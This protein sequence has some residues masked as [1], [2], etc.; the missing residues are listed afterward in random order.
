[1][2]QAMGV[3]QGLSRCSVINRPAAAAEQVQLWNGVRLDL[4]RCFSSRSPAK[5]WLRQEIPGI[6]AAWRSRLGQQCQQ[7]GRQQCRAMLRQ[8]ACLPWDIR[9]AAQAWAVSFRLW[10]TGARFQFPAVQLLARC[11]ALGRWAPYPAAPTPPRCLPLFTPASPPRCLFVA[12]FCEALEREGVDT[13][14]AHF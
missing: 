7:L 1:M 4:A 5:Q 10:L 9:R 13:L 2:Q 14:F 11:C 3:Q 12:P 6:N 8:A